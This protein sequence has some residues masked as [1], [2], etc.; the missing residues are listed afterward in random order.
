M[1]NTVYDNVTA[2]VPYSHPGMS[3]CN[4]VT[5]QLQRLRACVLLSLWSEW[6]G[7]WL[8]SVVSMTL[9]PVSLG[10]L[11]SYPVCAPLNVTSGL[12]WQKLGPKNSLM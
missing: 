12:L 5:S 7:M 4:N 2:V 8:C 11:E 3:A 1:C 10:P 6:L 9:T